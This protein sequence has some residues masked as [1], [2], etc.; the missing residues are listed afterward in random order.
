MMWLAGIW[1]FAADGPISF[2]GENFS[3]F[4]ALQ[5]MRFPTVSD[6]WFLSFHKVIWL[7][8]LW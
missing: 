4:G 2:G 5:H 1:T 8:A 7:P 3:L 6:L